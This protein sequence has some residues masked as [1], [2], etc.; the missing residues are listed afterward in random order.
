[1][2]HILFISTG[3]PNAYHPLDGIFFR[4]QAEALAAYGHQV[5]FIAV[6]PVSVKHI[7]QKKNISHLGYRHF[8]EKKVDTRHCAYINLPRSPLYSIK[9]AMRKGRRIADEYISENKT[10][11]II[12]MHCFEAVELA[13]YFINKYRIPL[14]VTE[15]SSRFL[16]N[17]L[18]PSLE[19]YAQ[20]AFS[21]SSAN[22][23]VS[24]V[25]AKELSRK[26]NIAF[27]YVPNVVDTDFFTPPAKIQND[28]FTFLNVAGLIPI[29][30]QAMLITA[31]AEVLKKHDKVRLVIVGEGP[32]RKR[33]EKQIGE[34]GIRENVILAGFL[35]RDWVKKYMQSADAFVLS[36][37]YETFG[38]VLIEAM[39]SG[40]PVVST[41]CSGPES[42]ITDERLGKLC[43]ISSGSLAMAMEDVYNNR[44]AYDS[45]F[46][47]KYAA[48]NFSN[49]AVSQ[50]LTALY[51][52][53]LGK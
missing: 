14:V 13:E 51:Q 4:D 5:G 18:H 31:F 23:A 39:S 44:T 30:S 25:L 38:V 35:G 20:K 50:K 21:L 34:L 48:D 41:K 8:T 43:D 1:M 29:K 16:N 42:I 27:Q 7:I 24:H 12:H 19:K 3:Y 40:L 2:L 36:S 52:N 28:Y 17:T 47:R 10:P 45:V 46:I 37:S 49:F 22:I 53:L 15:H 26:Y 9:Q 11:D 32:E 33:L 6:N